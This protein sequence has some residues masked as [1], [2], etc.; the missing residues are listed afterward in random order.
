MSMSTIRDG[1]L[2]RNRFSAT[3]IAVILSAATVAATLGPPAFLFGAIFFAAGAL[4]AVW[5]V[6]VNHREL[7][8]RDR[9]LPTAIISASG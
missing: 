6:V 5:A 2:R 8:R 7:L 1:V 9:S 4:L 3:M